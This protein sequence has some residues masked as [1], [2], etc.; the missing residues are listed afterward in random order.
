MTNCAKYL[1]LIIFLFLPGLHASGVESLNL[2][3]MEHDFTLKGDQFDGSLR[4]SRGWAG[5]LCDGYYDLRTHVKG[6]IKD[7]RVEIDADGEMDIG[8]EIR[9]I[10]GH[11]GGAYRSDLT[12]CFK[13]SGEF[14]YSIDWLNGRAHVNFVEQEPSASPEM[15]LR[16]I[17][18]E[19]GQVHVDPTGLFPVFDDLLRDF[20]N[21]AARRIWPSKLGEWI[22]DW[23]SEELKKKIPNQGLK[24]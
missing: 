24:L 13:T 1:T 8:I 21:S 4:R 11:V 18:T 5:V 20:I 19:F 6:T 12:G 9:H 23:V 22:S 15:K 14:P 7:L 3:Q 16:V 10:E 2:K 17:S